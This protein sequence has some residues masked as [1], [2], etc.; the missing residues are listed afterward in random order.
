MTPWTFNVKFPYDTQFTF[1]SLT[2]AA[3]E[4]G[5]LKILTPR[6]V[7]ER[8]ASVYG[9]APYLSAIS[10]TLGDVCSGL[11]PYAGPYYRTT[12]F[13]R[14]IR[15]EASILPPW[16]GASSSSSSAASPDQDSADD[17]SEI[18]GNLCWTYIEEGHLIIMVAP[19]GAPSCN[20]S[21]RYSTIGRSEA[22][23]ARTPNDGIIQ[24]LNSDF[25]VVWLQTII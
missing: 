12:R 8:L 11:N 7:P 23:N 17:Y 14:E 10:A 4:D 16:A 21:S 20:S 2:F 18:E 1:G 13:V 25:N 3:G 9:Q 19:V 24:N 22:S 5:N 6:L 15:I